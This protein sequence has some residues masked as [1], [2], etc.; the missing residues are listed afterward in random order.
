VHS[1]L[2]QGSVLGPVMYV[3]FINDLPKAVSS[4]RSMYADDTKVYNTVNGAS[5]KLQLQN[6]L[7]S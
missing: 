7:D 4:V 3:A 6:G 1:G 2:P 5:N